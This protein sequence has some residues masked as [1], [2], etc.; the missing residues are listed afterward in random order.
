MAYSSIAAT[1]ND[2]A[3]TEAKR[4][5]SAKIGELHL[6]LA[7]RS[8]R[9]ERFESE[10]PGLGSE[11]ESAVA[12]LKGQSLKPDGYISDL[13]SRLEAVRTEE[14][15]WELTARVVDESRPILEN[16][17][18]P[19]KQQEANDSGLVELAN[20]HGDSGETPESIGEEKPANWET[21]GFPV[22]QELVTRMALVLDDD[23]DRVLA[24]VTADSLWICNY[25]AN[26]GLG[27]MS[28]SLADVSELDLTSAGPGAEL[29]DLIPRLVSV[30][31]DSG[32]TIAR[33]LALAYVAVATW[34]AASD[35]EVADDEVA[36]ID[37]LRLR[38][39]EELSHGNAPINSTIDFFDQTF[40]H[41]VGMEEVKAELRKRIDFLVVNQRRTSRGLKATPQSL[42]MAFLGNP[43]TGKTVVAR[44][45]AE[46][47]RK[48]GLLSRG[49]VV[50]VDRSGLVGQYV[51]QTEKKTLDV[52]KKALGGVLFIDEA[53][54]IAN[55]AN[56]QNGYGQEIIDVLVK[57]LE[58]H[59]HDL[60]VI[61]AG[62]DQPMARFFATNEGLRSRVPTMV[63]FADFSSGQLAAIAER[64]AM[65]DGY[66]L[67][68]IAADRLGAESERLRGQDGFGNARTVRNLYEEALRNQS[69][70]IAG[71]GDLATQAE[72]R[73]I[74]EEDVPMV[75]I[76][77]KPVIG[78]AR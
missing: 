15:L 51:G 13:G 29:G 31:S 3:L 7:V 41:L 43:G 1:V 52:V 49:Q 66:T 42:H 11:L 64:M 56:G 62:Y 68:E 30:P 28:E 24:V 39:R 26:G 45:Y 17:G 60:V 65:S 78:F 19:A 22:T 34:A 6:L 8:C 77:T 16:T 9:P 35:S 27:A 58:D 61:F 21:S 23:T 50:E 54:A 59:R 10:Y 38:F 67:S 76:A 53:Y 70:R 20:S 57:Q 48:M 73:D 71:L 5:G 2:Y 40:E 74:S 25:V 36:K 37:E 69:A 18:G 47:L 55:D 32:L 46:V 44:L 72:L 63:H 75:E 12:Q 4:S 14:A 33:E